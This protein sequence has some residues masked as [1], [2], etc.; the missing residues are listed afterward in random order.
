MEQPLEEIRNKQKASWN[1]FSSGWKKWDMLT[2]D[3]LQPIGNSMITFINPKHQLMV[4]DIASGTGEPALT[5][6]ERLHKGKVVMTDLSDKMLDVARE[7]ATK[8]GILNVDTVVCDVCELPFANNT[9]DAV[10]CRFG[11]MF[12]PD[13]HLA[14]REMIRVLKPGGKLVTAVWGVPEKNIWVT[15]IANSIQQHLQL[16]VPPPEA[17]GMFR[18]A[19]KGLLK[20]IFEQEQLKNVFE[21]EVN[22]QLHSGTAEMYWNMMTEIAAPFVSA[23]S[24]AD[25]NTAATIKKEAIQTIEQ[26][27]G[28]VNVSIDASALVIGGEK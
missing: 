23:L 28:K 8:K 3:F 26:H 18:C 20:N 15:A 16:P 1:K 22:S 24:K 4:L 14:A 7:K 25:A 21:Q 5:I 6:A 17:P 13:M 19:K 9:F 2:M 27:F 12:F 10:T 11:F